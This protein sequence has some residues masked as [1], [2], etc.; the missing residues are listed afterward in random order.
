MAAG[1]GRG[2][3]TAPLHM[4]PIM[5]EA[6]DKTAHRASWFYYKG[7]I[8]DGLWVLHKCDNPA[9]VNPDHL[10]LGTPRD[11]TQDAIKKGRFKFGIA[12]LKTLRGE[13]HHRAKLTWAQVREM[14]SMRGVSYARLGSLFGVSPESASAIVRGHRWKESQVAALKPD[15]LP[16]PERIP[17]PKLRTM[18]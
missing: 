18:K 2:N 14:R 16:A 7:P 13:D 8:P 3:I 4:V 11:N 17:V 5:L 6:W 9:C 10:F 1:F 12:C 15:A